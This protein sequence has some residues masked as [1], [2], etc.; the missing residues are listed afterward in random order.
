MNLKDLTLQELLL[1][2]LFAWQYMFVKMQEEVKE[3]LFRR[4]F[5]P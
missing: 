2:G 4:G 5:K 3:E 1:L